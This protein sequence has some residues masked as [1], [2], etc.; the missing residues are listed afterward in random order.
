MYFQQPRKAVN[1]GSNIKKPKLKRQIILTLVLFSYL[2][3]SQCED[4]EKLNFGGTYLSKTRNYIPFDLD[5]SDTIQYCCDIKKIKKYSDFIFKKAEEYIIER[6][7]KEFYNNLTIHQLEVNYIDSIKI[8]YENQKL[9]NLSNYNV[10]YWIL[11]TYKNKNVEYGFGL[12]FDKN[13]KMISENK[14]PKYSENIDFENLTDYC[15]ALDLV[16]NDMRFSGKKVDYVELAY[17]DEMN[18]FCWLIEEQKEPNSEFGKWEERITNLYFVNA[19]T[20][21]LELVKEQKSMSIS[22]GATF[23]KKSRKQLRKEKR[24]TKKN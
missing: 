23:T 17:L 1:V 15:L 22:S 8:V 12:E 7:G 21:I 11:Y 13:G 24:K 5:I 6:G 3:F 4:S 18:S 19:N 16:K 2:G 9:Y 14:F 10:T 20:N